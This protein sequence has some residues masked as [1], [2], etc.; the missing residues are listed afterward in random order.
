MRR[1]RPLLRGGTVER[2]DAWVVAL[3][4]AIA[5][6]TVGGSPPHSFVAV[7]RDHDRSCIDRH[8]RA[9]YGGRAAHLDPMRAL[10]HE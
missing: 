10:R 8:C 2:E 9:A 7:Q 5:I 1:P 6:L 3:G 4:V